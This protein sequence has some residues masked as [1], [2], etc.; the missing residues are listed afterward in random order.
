M[1]SRL[2]DNS[3]KPVI[4]LTDMATPEQKIKKVLNRVTELAVL[5]HVVFQVLEA[6]ASS[7]SACSDIERA[8]IVDPG[9]SAKVLTLANS[10]SYGLPKKITAIREAI[11]FLGF[12]AVRNIA[13][14]VGVFDL[15]A[16]KTDNES[17]RRR[18]WWR[19]SIDAA[20]LGQWLAREAK[21]QASDEAYTCGLLHYVGKTLLDR[22][23]IGDYCQVEELIK[24][25]LDDVKAELEIYGISHDAVTIAAAEKWNLPA[26]LISGLNYR[27][28]VI[29]G[30]S[31]C[32]LRAITACASFL[33]SV[34]QEEWQPEV[35]IWRAP[36]WAFNLAGIDLKRLE[37]LVG[38]AQAM[39]AKARAAEAA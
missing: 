33:A 1:S 37:V 10:A 13:M 21:I 38:D 12:R 32:Q 7:D 26:Q 34:V 6:S 3:I 8:I 16:G 5:P 30:E 20:L 27:H 18:L 9:F 17:L 22:S 15:F 2:P 14:T 36:A 25:G 24:E 35:T 28:Q 39:L 11:A 29:E 31:D 4:N 19:H 23:G